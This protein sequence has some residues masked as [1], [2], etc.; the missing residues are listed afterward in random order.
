MPL[1]NQSAVK[2]ILYFRYYVAVAQWPETLILLHSPQVL[3]NLW[4][5]FMFDF[6]PRYKAYFNVKSERLIT[7][8][9]K[10]IESM[11]K[12]KALVEFQLETLN[13]QQ[14]NLA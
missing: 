5:F 8:L 6:E 12:E 2:N 9:V 14:E 7:Q 10:L 1:K 4:G 3:V 13:K 11:A